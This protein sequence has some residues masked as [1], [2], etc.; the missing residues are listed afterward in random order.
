MAGADLG[1]LDDAIERAELAAA[2]LGAGPATEDMEVRLDASPNAS[3]ALGLHHDGI[4][5]GAA[6]LGT[7]R[8][9]ALGLELVG[10][11][12]MARDLI[13]EIEHGLE[14]HRLRH[15]LRALRRK[16]ASERSGRGQ[17]IFTTHSRVAL[18]ELEPHEVAVVHASK[19]RTSSTTWTPPRPRRRRASPRARGAEVEVGVIR[20][21]D[22]VWAAAHEIGRSRT[23][24]SSPRW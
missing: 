17:V 16:V 14:P 11:P 4:P 15:L 2:Q 23:S 6:G 24:A 20:G 3:G 5:L 18:E 12:E 19:S 22:E 13:D 10:T 1:E 8:L 21:H 9:L 7:R